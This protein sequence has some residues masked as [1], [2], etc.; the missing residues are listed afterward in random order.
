M[1]KKAVPVVALCSVLLVGCNMNGNGNA[2]N[3]NETPMQDVR[4][5]VDRVVPE[6]NVNTPSPTHKN[7]NGV[8]N[9]DNNGVNGGVNGANNGINNVPEVHD[10]TVPNGNDNLTTPN[11]KNAPNLNNN[12]EVI[13]KEEIKK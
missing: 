12:E 13:I 4:E 10:N 3:N 1:L 6:P 2:P 11:A 7:E 9:N 5:G 8:N